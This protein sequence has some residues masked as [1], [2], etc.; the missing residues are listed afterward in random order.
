MDVSDVFSK[1]FLL[2]FNLFVV[3]LRA[4]LTWQTLLSMRGKGG[5]QINLLA[6]TNKLAEIMR[7]KLIEE[8]SF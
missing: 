8:Y 4:T 6:E 1:L 3:G 2:L 5:Q 7:L